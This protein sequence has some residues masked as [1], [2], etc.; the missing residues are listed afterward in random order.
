MTFALISALYYRADIHKEQHSQSP[1]FHLN[2]MRNQIETV[3]SSIIGRMP[4]SIRAITEKGFYLEVL[5]F[6]IA[7]LLNLLTT[8]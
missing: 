1:A 3:F 4:R 7:Y 2:S 5:F 6:I 8:L